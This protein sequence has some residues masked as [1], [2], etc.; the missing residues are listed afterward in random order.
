[1]SVYR[2]ANSPYYHFDF[3]LD[4]RRFLGSTGCT[5]RKE[6]EKFEAVEREKAKALVKASKRAAGSL[7]IDHVAPLLG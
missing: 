3:Q 1:M 2:K 7:Q 4:R 6:A 5:A